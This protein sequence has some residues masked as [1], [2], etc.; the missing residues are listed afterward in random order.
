MSINDIMHSSLVCRWCPVMPVM[1]F[2]HGKNYGW[3]LGSLL[4]ADH[5]LLIIMVDLKKES[6]L[7]QF[8]EIYANFG[9]LWGIIS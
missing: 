2:V 3:Y 5:I 8:S 4:N 7:S 1:K 6:P 9:L